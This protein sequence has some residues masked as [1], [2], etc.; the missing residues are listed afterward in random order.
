MKNKIKIYMILL[1]LW[2]IVGCSKSDIV[3]SIET[4]TSTSIPTPTIFTTSVNVKNEVEV[5]NKVEN[6]NFSIEKD[7]NEE[8]NFTILVVGDNLFHN[9]NLKS[10][11]DIETDT[12]DFTSFYKYVKP[13]IQSADIAIANLEVVIGGREAKITS[14]PQFNAPD[15]VLYA[16]DDAG[17]D[18]LITG[19]NHCLDR[20]YEGLVRTINMIEENNM[21]NVGTYLNED[22]RWTDI[23]VMGIT[24]RN[25]AYTYSC[26]GNIY[27]LNDEQLYMVNLLDESLIKEHIEKAKEDGIELINVFLHWGSEYIRQPHQW[28]EDF[29]KR[30]FSYGADIIFATHP[31]VIQKNEIYSINGEDKYIIYSTGNFISNFSRNDTATRGNKLYTEDGVIVEAT[32]I[33]DDDNKVTL[34][35]VFHIPTWPY[36]YYENDKPQYRIIPIQDID[37]LYSR[38]YLD[39]SNLQYMLK[40]A[41]NSFDRTFESLDNYKRIVNN[42]N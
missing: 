42:D 28:Q 23:E 22:I 25:L 40:E 39:I 9:D 24:V 37:T 3:Q 17:F 1:I 32:F 2:L 34:D 16:L 27:K 15:E 11:Y 38:E 21:K 30:V 19:N 26:N 18:L 41:A 14:Y 12:Y 13:Y 6:E 29:A 5:E 7:I 10:A 8:K 36:K 20:G 33:I 35:E 4:Y 31:H